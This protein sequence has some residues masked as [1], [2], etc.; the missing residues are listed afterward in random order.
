MMYYSGGFFVMRFVTRSSVSAMR[1][2]RTT[3]LRLLASKGVG[4]PSSRCKLGMSRF[5]YADCHS[6]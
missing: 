6:P 3:M 5:S 2:S 4:G 1:S